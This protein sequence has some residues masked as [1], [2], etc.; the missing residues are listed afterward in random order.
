[1]L[2]FSYNNKKAIYTVQTS[3]GQF[4][5]IK[6]SPEEDLEPEIF[7]RNFLLFRL[8]N[9]PDFMSDAKERWLNLR[10]TILSEESIL[11]RLTE[12]YDKARDAIEIDTNKKYHSDEDANWSLK[13]DEA[14]DYLYNWIPD[15]LEYCD[16]YFLKF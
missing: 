4:L 3:F 12:I 15:R 11:D 9:N 8:M 7:K 5:G 10:D 1:M 16:F 2:H 6:Y 13:V 14:I